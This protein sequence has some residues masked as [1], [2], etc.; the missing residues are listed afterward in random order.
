L[1][2]WAGLVR[3]GAALG[4]PEPRARGA[5]ALVEG[6][7]GLQLRAGSPFVALGS[8]LDGAVRE[9]SERLHTPDGLSG[10]ALDRWFQSHA[11]TSD[12]GETLGALR[13][14]LFG[15][16]DTRRVVAAAQ[17]VQRWRRR[18]VHGTE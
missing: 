8:L 1:A 17:A 6:A 9:V 13:Q 7:V 5:N 16:S 10:P 11:A 18:M 3:F 12:S 15:A 2:V 4:D 14:Q